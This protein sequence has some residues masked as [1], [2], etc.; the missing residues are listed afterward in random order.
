M[1]SMSE[2]DIVELNCNASRTE[3]NKKYTK[4][5]STREVCR[6]KKVGHV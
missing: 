2:Q 6:V 5:V 1:F 3:S 4:T